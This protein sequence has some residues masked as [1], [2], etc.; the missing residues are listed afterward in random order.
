M[1][2]IAEAVTGINVVVAG[3]EIAVVF[4]DEGGATALGEDAQGAGLASEVAKCN[5][6]VL[7][8]D[9]TDVMALSLIHI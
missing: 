1:H 3:V 5:I 4:E 2:D 8:E 9:F 6:E 7:N